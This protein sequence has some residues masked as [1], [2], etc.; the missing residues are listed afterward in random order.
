[1]QFIKQPNKYQFLQIKNQIHLIKEIYQLHKS[2]HGKL[3]YL[4]IRKK[5]PDNMVKWS[6]KN[7]LEEL[8]F[9]MHDS[10]SFEIFEHYQEPAVINYINKL[11]INDSKFLYQSVSLSKSNTPIDNVFR[12]SADI[13]YFMNDDNKIVTINKKFTDFTAEDFQN[14]DVWKEKTVE[15]NT[16]NYRYGNK[17]PVWQKSMNSR[18]YD[19]N[20]EGLRNDI[21][22]SSLHNISNGH[23]KDMDEL[24]DIKAQRSQNKKSEIEYFKK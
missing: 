20:N 1:M 22:K 11:F 16:S 3:T 5:V 17:I 12:S 13:G 14:L 18:H 23:K 6:S 21:E 7:N 9:I 8:D 19:S 10:E 15:S 4:D 2:N 24:L